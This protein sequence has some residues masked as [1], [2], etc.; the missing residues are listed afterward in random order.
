MKAMV[1][2]PV[3][4]RVPPNHR[5]VLHNGLG[6]GGARRDLEAEE[7]A[8]YLTKLRSLVPD[9]PRKRKLSKLEVIQRVIEYICDLQT[10]LEETN[11]AHQDA[12]TTTIATTAA[13]T[14][15]TTAPEA[16]A[17]TTQSS[18]QPL[19]PL[20]NAAASIA[21][22]T[23]TTTT[24]ATVADRASLRSSRRAH[25]PRVCARGSGR[26]AAPLFEEGRRPPR[27]DLT[28]RSG[29]RWSRCWRCRSSPGRE[30]AFGDHPR[31]APTSEDEDARRSVLPPCEGEIVNTFVNTLIA[32]HTRSLTVIR[33]RHE[34]S[35]PPPSPPPS[36]TPQTAPCPKSG[37]K[38]SKASYIPI[39][40]TDRATP[41][42][43]ISALSRSG[44]VSRSTD[45]KA[46]RE[47]ALACLDELYLREIG[48]TR[49]IRAFRGT[50]PSG[51]ST[52]RRS[53]RDATSSAFAC[54]ERTR[55]V[56]YTRVILSSA[57]PS[58][59]PPID[60][61]FS[62]RSSPE[63]SLQRG[64]SRVTIGEP[65]ISIDVEYIEDDARGDDR[66]DGGPAAD[67]RFV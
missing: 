62:R 14:M 27:A 31:G 30:N 24:V 21:T 51:S 12:K 44:S 25:P 18:I 45:W 13:T 5:G 16:T 66:S 59:S 20:L 50:S 11:A 54:T 57:P 52:S 64:Q 67:S 39:L 23:T 28:S 33:I 9:M 22:T 41:I 60:R 15:S 1:V 63:K 38:T 49:S 3:S 7:V 40:A 65:R 53:R 36:F 6:I 17:T 61:L 10:A 56:R 55:N 48:K 34:P 29:S 26:S 19:Q 46:T 58:Q 35:F 43:P 4:G 8:A 42:E 47:S 37:R 2:S 32:F